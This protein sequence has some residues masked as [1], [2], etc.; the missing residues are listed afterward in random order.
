MSKVI[1]SSDSDSGAWSISVKAVGGEHLPQNESGGFA[2]RD[3]NVTVSPNDELSSL[4]EQI[5]GVTGLK[6]SQQRLIYR[7]RLIG[8][9][10]TPQPTPPPP[11]LP[12]TPVA[13]NANRDGTATNGLQLENIEAASNSPTTE[14]HKRQKIKDIV[15]LGDGQTIHL[16]KKR[17]TPEAERPRDETTVGVSS[18]MGAN[19]PSEQGSPAPMAG[20]GTASLLAALL[21]LGSLEDGGGA[22]GSG[23]GGDDPSASEENN[24]SRSWRANRYGNRR[25]MH[26][27]LSEEDIRDV[28]DPGSAEP[29]RQSMM[30]LHTLL[31]HAQHGLAST[32]DPHEQQQHQQLHSPLDFQRRWYRGQWV[33]C[34]DTV[35]QWLEATVV[36]IIHPDDILPPHSESSSSRPSTS[37]SPTINPANDPAVSAGDLEGRRRLL[38]EPCMEGCIGDLGGELAGFRPRVTN[39]GVQ[40]ILLHYNGW[41]HRWDEWIRS[42]SE[43]LRPFRV[44]TR[45]STRST[46]ASPTPQTLFNEAPSTFIR[47]E[48]ETQDREALLP[49]LGRILTAVNELV[50]HAAASARPLAQEGSPCSD[51]PWASC[52]QEGDHEHE[53]EGEEDDDDLEELASVDSPARE[54]ASVESAVPPSYPGLSR[55]ELETLAPLLDRLG[56]TLIDAAPHVASLAASLPDHNRAEEADDVPELEPVDEHPSTLG[57]LL[58]LLSRDRRRGAS[59][60]SSSQLVVAGDNSSAITPSVQT[61]GTSEA[62]LSVDPDYTDFVTGLVNTSRGEVRAGPRSLRASQ[63]SGDDLSNVL[64]AYL[65]AASMGGGDEGGDENGNSQG[66]GRLLR[67]RGNGGGID[68]HIHAVVTSPGGLP[69][70]LGLATIGGSPPTTAGN[71]FSHNRDR[72][73]GGPLLRL[74]APAVLQEEDDNGIFSALYS[75]NPTPINPNQSPSDRNRQGD[76][77]R[78]ND[79]G[80]Q[81]VRR[82]LVRSR[83]SAAALSPGVPRSSRGSG[84]SLRRGSSRT[85]TGRTSSRGMLNR[86]FRRSNHDGE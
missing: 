72:R 65:A 34:R 80:T 38:L 36:E 78:S 83:S 74:R 44:R 15:G 45:H 27:R 25:R 31:P 77:S 16:V 60:T 68:I 64:G 69:G 28:P 48:V 43:R 22:G 17:D 82:R 13:S 26:Y 67:E 71:V 61:G 32:T 84:S 9:T 1:S 50:A 76:S 14:K 81:E 33:D 56:R 66:L 39:D 46:H 24:A 18:N 85:S 54:V 35:N 42:D 5:E 51:L 75:E 73:S 23:S 11:I 6:A 55:R 47:S 53:L 10:S 52:Q 8:A 19:A 21:G 57:G 62:A 79:A 7:G 40:M 30:T 41:P 2:E 37:Q 63:N 3:F 86:F 49:E 59:T 12:S 20:N 70:G 29:V 58:S 4:Y